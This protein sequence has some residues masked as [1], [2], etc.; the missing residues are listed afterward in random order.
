MFAV[1]LRECGYANA[2]WVSARFEFKCRQ[3]TRAL[4]RVLFRGAALLILLIRHHIVV[5]LLALPFD[6][7]MQK[8]LGIRHVIRDTAQEVQSMIETED[9]GYDDAN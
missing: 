2:L 1:L 4:G 7:G 9:Y 3:I 8:A 5:V 6:L